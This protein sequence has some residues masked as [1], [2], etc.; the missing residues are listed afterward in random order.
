MFIELT[1]FLYYC[2]CCSNFVCS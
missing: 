2:Y 1:V